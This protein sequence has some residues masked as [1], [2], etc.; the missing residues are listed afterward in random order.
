MFCC[1]PVNPRPIY[2]PLLVQSQNNI[3]NPVVTNQFGYFNNPSPE[4]IEN[5]T[6]IPLS[7]VTGRGTNIT[8][9]TTT[10]GA[11]TLLP[12]TYQVSYMANGVTPTGE[13]VTITLELNGVEVAGSAV[14]ASGAAGTSVVLGQ[15]I[16]VNVP[17]TSTLELVNTSGETTEFFSASMTIN[18]L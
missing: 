5:N 17:G 2:C 15:T 9:S 11:I 1:R 12:G 4:T 16:I 18:R 7:L 3:V 10:T 13:N 14:T 8:Q 6:I